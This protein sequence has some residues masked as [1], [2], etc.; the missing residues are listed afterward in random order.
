MNKNLKTAL[1]FDDVLLKPNFSS[2]LPKE[3]D[4][5]IELSKHLNLNIPFLSAAMDTVTEC[6]L[7]ISLARRGG[8]GTL[9]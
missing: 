4:L 5:S 3:V 9:V 1:T 2:V 8:M 7:A 6:K